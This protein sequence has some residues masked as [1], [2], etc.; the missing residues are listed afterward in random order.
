MR[1]WML[2]LLV[3]VLSACP[4]IPEEDSTFAVVSEPYRLDRGTPEDVYEYQSSSSY[5]VD[6]WWW[7]QGFAVTFS[8]WNSGAGKESNGWQVESE[9]R[10]SPIP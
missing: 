10:F 3:V 6:W 8:N 5:L 4:L 7:T 1:L 2:C 9:Y